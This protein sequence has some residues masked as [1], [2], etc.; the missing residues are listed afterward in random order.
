MF[1]RVDAV[2]H[3]PDL[4]AP[5]RL[6]DSAPQDFEDSLVAPARSVTTAIR[7]FARQMVDQRESAPDVQENR[8]D[9]FVQVLSLAAQM[10]DPEN[11]SQSLSQSMTLA[12]ARAAVLELAG[13]DIR[14]NSIV[15][16]GP[17]AEASQPWLMSRT[18]LQ[19]ATRAEEIAEAAM[20]LASRGASN[21]TGQV[22]TMDGGRSV[23]NGIVTPPQD[24]GD[25]QAS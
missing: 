5:S 1:S 6:M 14:T 19:R 17:R 8:V 20:F 13:M 24:G 7:L 10:S 22:I 15:A 25:D 11:Y 23:L 18:P 16:V 4:P 2:V 3:V 9:C 12:A 21:V